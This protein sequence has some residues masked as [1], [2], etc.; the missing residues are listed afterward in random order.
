MILMLM[1]A[2]R[3]I[4]HRVSGLDL[5]LDFYFHSFQTLIQVTVQSIFK[6]L[7]VDY[8]PFDVL[9]ELPLH[10]LSDRPIDEFLLLR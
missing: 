1:V 2:S 10:Y 9:F 8:G 3:T 5:A 7:D 4:H 6:A